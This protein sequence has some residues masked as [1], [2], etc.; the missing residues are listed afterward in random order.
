MASIASEFARLPEL[1]LGYMLFPAISLRS[2]RLK[3]SQRLESEFNIRPIHLTQ[4]CTT[5]DLTSYHYVVQVRTFLPRSWRGFSCRD[6]SLTT[7]TLIL[8]LKG[9]MIRSSSAAHLIWYI[10]ERHSWWEFVSVSIFVSVHFKVE[11]APSYF[12]SIKTLIYSTETAGFRETQELPSSNVN[13]VFSGGRVLSFSRRA[14]G[15]GQPPSSPRHHRIRASNALPNWSRLCHRSHW[16]APIRHPQIPSWSPLRVQE[17]QANRGSFAATW[18]GAGKS[19]FWDIS[20]E[21]G[22]WV[23]SVSIVLNLTP[24]LDG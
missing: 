23:G 15:Q 17:W 6:T 3:L 10:F 1:L 19:A 21:R 18:S 8:N 9:P 16:K 13:G 11:N 20:W 7:T 22:R 12:S 14:Y 5:L 2:Q 4:F 24:D